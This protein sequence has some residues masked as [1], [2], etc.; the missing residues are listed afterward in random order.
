M[1]GIY[2]IQNIAAVFLA[3][4][5]LVTL[6]YYLSRRAGPVKAGKEKTRI[7][8]CGEDESPES[9]NVYE[10]GFFRNMGRILGIDKLRN[11]HDGDLTSYLTWIF[12]GM[13]ILI[14]VMVMMW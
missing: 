5:A 9:M 11:I 3:V 10:S 1:M 12:I 6:V 13:V 14:L 8:A 2:V 4:L 7:Y